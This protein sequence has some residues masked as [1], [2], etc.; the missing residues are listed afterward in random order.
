MRKKL[1]LLRYPGGKSRILERLHAALDPWMNDGNTTFYEPFVGGGSLTLSLLDRFANIRAS[2]NDLDPNIFSFWD[3]M[4]N[5]EDSEVASMQSML[6]RGASL[7]IFDAERSRVN[8]EG[9][10]RIDR[11]YHAVFFCKTTHNGMFTAS[12]IGGRQQ[13]GKQWKIDCQYNPRNM[14][15]TI[16]RIRGLVRGRV[17]VTRQSA[18]SLIPSVPSSSPIYLDPPYYV[19]GKK[20]YPTY[21]SDKEHGDLSSVLRQR[22]K[23]VLSYDDCPEIRDLY[24]W[25]N[26][27]EIPMKYSMASHGAKR[28]WTGKVELLILPK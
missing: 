17:E 22:D 7:D 6:N 24:K 16:G 21:M 5:G 26:I 12:P 15:K 3:L 9:L 8:S 28:D 4:V 20:C 11:A 2:I 18:M 13:E 10:S 27:L 1:A 23:W 25:A 14:A 19:A